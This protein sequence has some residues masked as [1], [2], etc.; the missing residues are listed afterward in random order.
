M[1]K[2]SAYA[3]RMKRDPKAGYFNGAEWLNTIS[4]CRSFNEPEPIPGSWL[5]GTAETAER[6]KDLVQGSLDRLISGQVKPGETDPFDML[7]HAIGVSV[8]RSNQTKGDRTEAAEVL[9]LAKTALN[10]VKARWQRLG[11][12]GATRP[13]QL[14]LQSGVDLYV[15]FLESSSPE[16][17]KEAANLR[18]DILKAQGW[19][20]PEQERKAA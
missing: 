20:E 19:V 18:M 6:M 4:R 17:M 15:Q 9:W 11:K 1:R 16:Q 5:P 12:W 14:A 3:R 8:V 2:T 13:E 10:S 7:A